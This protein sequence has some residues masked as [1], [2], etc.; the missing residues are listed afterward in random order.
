M[1]SKGFKGFQNMAN[2]A[3]GG[4]PF[5]RFFGMSVLG[6]GIF[7]LSN[8]I[9]YGKDK[10]ILVDVGHYAVKWNKLWGGLNSTIYREGYNFR[11]P[12]IELPI[13]YNVQ[14]R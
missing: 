13:V 3:A 8:S 6:L 2:N 7:L 12:I 9:Y 4:N 1:N 11:I 10:F 14:T 5:Q